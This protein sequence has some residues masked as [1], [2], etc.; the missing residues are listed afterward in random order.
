VRI[1]NKQLTTDTYTPFFTYRF[2]TP[3]IIKHIAQTEGLP[4]L[5]KG[6]TANVV[7]VAPSRAIYFSCF[8]YTK[9]LFGDD[10]PK[11]HFISAAFAGI[12]T[13]TLTQ[14]IWLLKTRIQLQSNTNPIEST[15]NPVMKNYRGYKDAYARIL[16]E[17]GVVGFYKGLTASYWNVLEGAIQFSLYSNFKKNALVLYT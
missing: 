9:S 1:S 2:S 4:G 11:I 15:Y 16:R 13:S 14:P 10:S 6:L 12:V 7:G 5:F 17:E 8:S 3:Q